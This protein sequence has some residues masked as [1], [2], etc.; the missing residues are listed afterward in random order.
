MTNAVYCNSELFSITNST[1]TAV[2]ETVFSTSYTTVTPTDSS[3]P[4]SSSTTE[5]PAG[6]TTIT[7]TSSSSTTAQ[8]ATTTSRGGGA[9]TPG[10]QSEQGTLN[11]DN[12]D[13][14]AGHFGAG[15]VVVAGLAALIAAAAM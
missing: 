13:S 15:G 7:S 3:S 1:A 11:A 12:L 8:Q 6:T 14:S 5:A 9:M 4:S 10:G 2:T